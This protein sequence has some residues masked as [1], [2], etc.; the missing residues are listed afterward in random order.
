VR[1]ARR[2]RSLTVPRRGPT[3]A[4]FVA[5]GLFYGAWASVL[6]SVQ[7]ATHT[8]KAGIGFALLFVVLAAIPA[9]LFVARP[10]TERFGT[11]AV[12]FGGAAFAAATTLPGLAGS[13]PALVV[14]LAAVGIASGTLDVAMNASAGRIEAV[15][16]KRLMPLAHGLYSTG[17]LVA[18]VGAGIARGAGASRE[19]IL[20]AVAALIAVVALFTATDATPIP[21][22][23]RPGVRLVRAVVVVGLVGAAG[24]VVEG[25]IENWSA[26]FLERQLHAQ[27]AISGLGPGFY[28]AAMATGRFLG[29]GLRIADRTLLVA[30][31]CCAAV[32]C[33]VA[34]V[35]GSAPVALLGFA[36]GGLGVSLNAP[37]VFGVAGR[38]SPAALATVTTLGYLGLL[39]GP[40]LVGLV[41]QAAGLRSAFLVLAAVAAVAAAVSR[42]VAA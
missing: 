2:D 24:F 19:A 35:A 7:R 40:P 1:A 13:L 20:L 37:L 21:S 15:S 31:G 8:S 17:L 18:A 30:S 34:A 22:G 25:G 32:G 33:A 42:K 5:L 28:A 27:P 4:A 29:Q 11:R 38:R 14:A 9:M 36:V 3:L 12:T 39:I 6:P 16:G 23:D 41:G 26:F 10:L